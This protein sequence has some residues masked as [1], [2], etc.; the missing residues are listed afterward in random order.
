M[1]I[2]A[3]KCSR[4]LTALQKKTSPIA[5][6]PNWAIS[7][8]SNTESLTNWSFKVWYGIYHTGIVLGFGFL[9]SS[10]SIN[11]GMW[12]AVG[13]LFLLKRFVRKC[14]N[15]IFFWAK[16]FIA[17]SLVCMFKPGWCWENLF[18]KQLKDVKAWLIS[19]AHHRR[20]KT[21]FDL[22]Q[23]HFI[24]GEAKILPQTKFGNLKLLKVYLWW[25]CDLWRHRLTQ[26]EFQNGPRIVSYH[27]KLTVRNF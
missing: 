16:L 9:L 8:F 4:V 5:S 19:S 13:C 7:F 14:L 27:K 1:I 6:S 17:C 21:V 12:S 2:I 18:Q 10:D 24:S 22:K 25:S 20:D 15:V 11:I 26:I 23:R 3:R